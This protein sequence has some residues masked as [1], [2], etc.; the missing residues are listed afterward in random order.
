MDTTQL[1]NFLFDPTIGKIVAVIVGFLVIQT[2]VR[3]LS[4]TVEEQVRERGIRYQVRRLITLT[5]YISFVVFIT[6][7][8]SDQLSSLTVALGVAGAGI[9]FALQEVISSIAG[10]YK[11]GDRVQLGGIKGD[12]IDIAILRTT[13]M[14]IGEWVKG[15]Q[16]SGR[17][18]RIANSFVFKEPVFNYSGDFPFLWDEIVLPV[19]YGSD[20]NSA[21]QIL[22]RVIDAE[23]VEYTQKASQVWGRMTKKYL[24]EETTVEPT[25]NLALNDN[26]ID[27]TVRYVVDFKKRRST[28]DRVFTRILDEFEKT[29]GKVAIAS[30]TI[31][32]VDMPALDVRLRD[33]SPS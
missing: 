5:G 1:E 10:F 9:A 17:I 6:L 26:W 30:T 23:T 19:K 27:F 20:H 13:L 14:E 16:Y 29:D 12:V 28:K 3:L 33:A 11:I 32:L 18:V 31:H 2:L 7:V 8:F 4:R 15:D 25:I 22:Q 24:V 21:R